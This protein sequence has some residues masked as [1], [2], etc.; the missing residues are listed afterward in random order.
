MSTLTIVEIIYKRVICSSTSRDSFTSIR[1]VVERLQCS[2][3]SRSIS[4]YTNA[5]FSSSMLRIKFWSPLPVS[6]RMLFGR[7]TSRLRK[8]W[9]QRHRARSFGAASMLLLASSLGGRR[10]AKVASRMMYRVDDNG[11]RDS[12]PRP[13]ATDKWSSRKPFQRV[14]AISLAANRNETKRLMRIRRAAKDGARQWNE[15]T[16]HALRLAVE[17]R[18]ICDTVDN[19]RVIDDSP[20][21]IHRFSIVFFVWTAIFFYHDDSMIPSYEYL[22]KVIRATHEFIFRFVRSNRR[23]IFKRDRNIATQWRQLKLRRNN[24]ILLPRAKRWVDWNIRDAIRIY[25]Y[26]YQSS[27]QFRSNGNI[28]T[29]VIASI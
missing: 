21:L 8:L 23:C 15:K 3:I 10:L 5:A 17:N 26:V 14:V 22:F 20:S 25:I 6:V 24:E 2:S 11:A 4:V 7:R 19:A 1:R 18:N 27:S 9:N 13:F 16:P 29:P 12:S 28:F